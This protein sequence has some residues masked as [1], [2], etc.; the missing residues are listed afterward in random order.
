MQQSNSWIKEIVMNTDVGRFS[1]FTKE[2]HISLDKLEN[3]TIKATLTDLRYFVKT[4]IYIMQLYIL[5]EILIRWNVYSS[6][7]I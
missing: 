6:H 4:G 1:E 7:I 2:Y 3:G 5:I